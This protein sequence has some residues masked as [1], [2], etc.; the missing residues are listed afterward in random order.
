MVQERLGFND[1]SFIIPDNT[2]PPDCDESGIWTNLTTE[3]M[4]VC[5]ASGPHKIPHS[6]YHRCSLKKTADQ[7]VA[8]SVWTSII[9]DDE[10][11]DVGNMHDKVTQNTRITIIKAGTYRFFYQ[12]KSDAQ[13][14]TAYDTRIYKNGAAILEG[15][16]NNRVGSKDASYLCLNLATRSFVFAVDDYF[17]LQFYH[18]D[19]D[20]QDVMASNTFFSIQRAY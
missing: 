4:Y 17:E 15:T 19:D 18:D 5:F 20:D 3:E 7:A 10:D 13:D 2:I 16:C 8:G 14:K 1:N 6:G 9:F 11:E 12:V